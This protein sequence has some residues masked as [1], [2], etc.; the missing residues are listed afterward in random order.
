MEQQVE[1][2]EWEANVPPEFTDDPLWR[3]PVYR[4]AAYAADIAWQDSLTLSKTALTREP[5]GELYRSVCGIA[6]GV[7]QGYSYST[8]S[9]R[10]HFLEQAMGCARAARDWYYR[11]RHVLRDEITSHRVGLLTRIIKTL[12]VQVTQQ[13]QKGLRE[14]GADATFIDTENELT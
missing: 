12:A 10:A 6:A 13:R 9:E 1:Y 8:G 14:A 4:L 7:V 2:E 11:T 5:A 3:L